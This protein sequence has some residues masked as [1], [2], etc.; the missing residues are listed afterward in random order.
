MLSDH[1]E[2]RLRVSILDENGRPRAHASLPNDGG[3]FRR[4]RL[5]RFAS[6]FG[7]NGDELTY[8]GWWTGWNRIDE[9]SRTLGAPFADV[10]LLRTSDLSWRVWRCTV[11]RCL[12]VTESHDQSPNLFTTD[13][14]DWILLTGPADKVSYLYPKE[15][16]F[17]VGSVQRGETTSKR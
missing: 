3:T 11:E 16:W 15:N 12:V 2:R 10:E 4:E 9:Y 14:A 5:E 6:L 7:I 13:R 17:G 1:L 8:A